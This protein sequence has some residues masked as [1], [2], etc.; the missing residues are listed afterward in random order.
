MYKYYKQEKIMSKTNHFIARIQQRGIL[1]ST[2]EMAQTYG[3]P[4]GDKFILGKK[5]IDKPR[6]RLKAED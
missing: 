3:L 1:Q 5:Q 6:L 4:K 2:I